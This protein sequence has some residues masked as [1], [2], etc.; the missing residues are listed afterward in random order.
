LH[1]SRFLSR[2]FGPFFLC[3]T[4]APGHSSSLFQRLSVHRSQLRACEDGLLQGGVVFGCKIDFSISFYFRSDFLFLMCRPHVTRSFASSMPR[5]SSPP[6]LPRPATK[7]HSFKHF[8]LFFSLAHFSDGPS[9]PHLR[10]GHVS[11]MSHLRHPA[12]QPA[13]AVL[14]SQ[15]H[16]ALP[17]LRQAHGRG[18]LLPHPPGLF[19]PLPSPCLPASLPSCIRHFLHSLC[20]RLS[21]TIFTTPLLLTSSSVPSPSSRSSTQSS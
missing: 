19:A 20:H 12:G 15:V 4:T 8:A 9:L 1:C 6:F 11:P 21:P 10:G 2:R 5:R 18:R 14:Q 3:L 16:R 7:V 13:A 17:L